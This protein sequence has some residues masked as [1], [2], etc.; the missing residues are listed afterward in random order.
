[1]FDYLPFIRFLGFAQQSAYGLHRYDIF[2]SYFSHTQDLQHN[3]CHYHSLPGLQYTFH[4][5]DLQTHSIR[6]Y[7]GSCPCMKA[8]PSKLKV[9]LRHLFM[10]HLSKEMV[11]EGTDFR[12]DIGKKGHFIKESFYQ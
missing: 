12:V 10:R 11:G 5:W 3:L 7:Q 1:M 4:P 6:D 2:C 9:V 8:F